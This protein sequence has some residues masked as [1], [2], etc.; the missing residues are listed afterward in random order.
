MK[1]KSK[2]PLIIKATLENRLYRIYQN[3]KGRCTRTYNSAYHLYGGRGIKV[4]DEWLE[5]G[6]GWI[7]FANWAIE[8]GYKDNLSID[9]IDVN[10]NYEPSNCR[11]TT[12]KRQGLN[13]RNTV[14]HNNE[15]LMDCAESQNLRYGTLLYREKAGFSENR[16]FER[17]KRRIVRYGNTV[18][19]ANEFA[20]KFGINKNSLQTAFNRNQA[21]EYILRIY[22]E[23]SLNPLLID[24]IDAQV[25]EV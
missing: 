7:N 20:R 2:K 10:G 15:P 1:S 14:Y 13:R 3:M 12:S 16:M 24:T 6:K 21:K 22:K 8:N 4:C 5:D 17:P 9:R 19:S 18:Y 25:I 23:T 11:W